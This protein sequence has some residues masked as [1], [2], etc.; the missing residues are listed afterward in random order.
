MLKEASLEEVFVQERKRY[1]R[2]R[3]YT[4]K[5]FDLDFYRKLYRSYRYGTGEVTNINTVDLMATLQF[6]EANECIMGNEPWRLLTCLGILAEE[7]LVDLTLIIQPRG[8]I[9]DAPKDTPLVCNLT[10]VSNPYWAIP[11]Y[12]AGKTQLKDIT[13]SVWFFDSWRGRYVKEIYARL[14]PNASDSLLKKADNDWFKIWYTEKW[15]TKEEYAERPRFL[16]EI[17]IDFDD[18]VVINDGSTEI[19]E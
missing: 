6:V 13:Q 8:D 7:G 16:F 17:P 11:A 3:I 5:R 15:L 9:P 1:E 18:V 4:Y 2:S 19:P 10:P 14:L 12:V